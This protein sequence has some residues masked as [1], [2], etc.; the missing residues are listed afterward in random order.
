M[1][2][3]EVVLSVL[4]LIGALVTTF[5]VPYIKSKTTLQQQESIQQ[6]VAV[7]VQAAEQIY[8]GSGRGSEKKKYVKDFLASKGYTLDTSAVEAL[9]E[10]AVYE[11]INGYI[12]T[13]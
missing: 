1:D 5:L 8:N 10:A 7:A 6:W 11:L 9:I 4:T 3:T 12:E 2:L 13:V